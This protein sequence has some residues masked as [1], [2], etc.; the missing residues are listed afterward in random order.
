MACVLSCYKY[1]NK[2]THAPHSSSSSSQPFPQSLSPSQSH[3]LGIHGRLGDSPPH[4]TCPYGQMAITQTNE[5]TNKHLFIGSCAKHIRWYFGYSENDSEVFRP[6]GA[7]RCTMGCNVGVEVSILPRKITPHCGAPR[8]NI[9][10]NF[11][12]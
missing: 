2:I 3:L 8:I 7:T 9:S 6:V 1:T 11:G 10:R 4:L 5:Q 12:I